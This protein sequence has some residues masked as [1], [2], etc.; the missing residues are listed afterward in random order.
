VT[1]WGT[2]NVKNLMTAVDGRT[3]PVR[4]PALRPPP[5]IDIGRLTPCPAPQIRDASG[6]APNAYPGGDGS[7]IDDLDIQSASFKTS[8]NG[9]AL[10]VTL[11]VKDLATQPLPPNM[12]SAELEV[13][14]TAKDNAGHPV[15]YQAQATQD[16]VGPA[17]QFN[18]SV[19]GSDGS[20]GA[21]DG[22]AKTGPN[23]TLSW[24]IPLSE[25]GKPPQGKMLYETSADTR[26]LI[27]VL[28]TGLQYVGAADRAP[29]K[30]FGAVW[31]I[32]AH[33]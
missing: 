24:T 12:V 29:D 6:D 18:F 20:G 32:G 7:N 26:G 33:C 5:T 23:G 14:W 1:G 3:A 8:P 28:G 27:A 19:Q 21:V 10:D 15:L 4:T 31:R 22:T 13:S 16:G 11:K 25:I 2:P 9:K 30:G 17:S